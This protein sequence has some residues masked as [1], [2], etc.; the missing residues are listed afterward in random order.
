[1]KILVVLPDYVSFAVTLH[2]LLSNIQVAQVSEQLMEI[3]EECLSGGKRMLIFYTIYQH[4]GYYSSS[5][6]DREWFLLSV[7]ENTAE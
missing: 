2:C 3:V 1:M 7:W 5:F 4:A 6:N